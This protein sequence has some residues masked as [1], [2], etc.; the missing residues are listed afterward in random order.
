MHWKLAY[1]IWLKINKIGFSRWFMHVDLV[2]IDF[3]KYLIVETF[4]IYLT[5]RFMN[6]FPVSF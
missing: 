6:F 1:L 3:G 4:V 2:V 5:S